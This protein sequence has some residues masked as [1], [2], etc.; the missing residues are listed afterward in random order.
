V[1]SVD[2]TST[3]RMEF[4]PDTV[5]AVVYGPIPPFKV[6]VDGY[7][8]SDYT[9]KVDYGDNA[10]GGTDPYT[11]A[12]TYSKQGTFPISVRA[13]DY[14]TDSLISTGNL[15][16]VIR[17]TLHSLRITGIPR[18]TGVNFL[19]NGFLTAPEIR[20]LFVPSQPTPYLTY[21]Y[22]LQSASGLDTTVTWSIDPKDGSQPAFYLYV[23]K[24]EV[25]TLSVKAFD[26]YGLRYI[27]DPWTTDRSG[28]STRV[29]ECDGDL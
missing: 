3:H 6:R 23:Q 24:P 17:D 13:F 2:P 1:T 28:S 18:D 20:V 4:N 7:A 8:Q 22:R 25:Y 5:F 12:H 15:T 27:L 19:R 26:R 21:I 9:W 10:T 16:A 29:P 14:F 11:R